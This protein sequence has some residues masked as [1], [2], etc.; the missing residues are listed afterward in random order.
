MEKYLFFLIVF[1]FAGFI[2]FGIP[3]LASL[4]LTVI[5]SLIYVAARYPHPLRDWPYTKEETGRFIILSG[6]GILL[7]ILL[8]NMRDYFATLSLNTVCTSTILITIVVLIILGII[9]PS[10]IKGVFQTEE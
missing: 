3:V 5:I 2:I 7:V 6:F 1:G 4:M 9:F 10:G 8:D